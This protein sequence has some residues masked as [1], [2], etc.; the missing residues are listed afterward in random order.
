MGVAAKTRSGDLPE[1]TRRAA[2]G[3]MRAIG[4]FEGDCT[5]DIR[6]FQILPC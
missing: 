3:R 4:A 5:F 1:P 2:L 6:A